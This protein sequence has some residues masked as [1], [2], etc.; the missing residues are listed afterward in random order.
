[1]GK[2]CWFNVVLPFGKRLNKINSE[3]IIAQFNYS[4]IT[5]LRAFCCHVFAAN[6]LEVWVINSGKIESS[7]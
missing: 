2:F 6:A 5:G 4:L 7:Q 3:A 1:M